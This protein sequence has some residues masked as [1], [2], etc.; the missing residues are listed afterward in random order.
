[1]ETISKSR[2]KDIHSAL[3]SIA[4]ELYHHDKHTGRYNYLGRRAHLLANQLKR[5]YKHI[6]QDK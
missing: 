5:H 6:L 2:I 3:S 1:M 4:Q